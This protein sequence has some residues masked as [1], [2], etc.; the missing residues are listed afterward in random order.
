MLWNQVAQEGGTIGWDFYF[1]VLLF[2]A[3]IALA[4]PI[5]AAIATSAVVM[6]LVSGVLPMSLFGESL[7][8]GID[9][10][11]P[12]GGPAGLGYVRGIKT[13][14]PQEWFFKA[15]F[16]QDPVCPGSLG[17][18][19][20]LQLLKVVAVQRWQGDATSI[21]ESVAVGERHSWNYRGQIVPANHQV[22]VEA[23]VTAV[24]D[25]Q[26]LLKADGFLSVD[27]KVIYRMKDFSIRLKPH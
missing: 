7:F 14:D 26:K 20:F 17:I 10:F 12:D 6:L 1:P 22:L 5:W 11:A 25:E 19:S 4:V 3:L 9:H 13:I 2:L 23:V 27:G 16:F 15:H 8:D 24:D 18:E 21:L